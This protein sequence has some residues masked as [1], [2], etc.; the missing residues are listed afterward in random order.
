MPKFDHHY[1]SKYGIG[2]LV[3]T[4]GGDLV[5][6]SKVTFALEGNVPTPYYEVYKDGDYYDFS[7]TDLKCR[8][9]EESKNG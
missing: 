7:E 6:I 1:S 2:D 4:V 9:V 8:M 5:K 3:K